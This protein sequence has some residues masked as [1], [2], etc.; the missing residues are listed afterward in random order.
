MLNISNPPHILRP[1]TTKQI[2]LDVIIA[3]IPAFLVSALFFGINAI[4]VIVTSVTA[5]VVFEYLSSRFWFKTKDYTSDLSSVIT[6]LLM[7][8]CLPATIP[9]W[10]II[11]GA[12]IAIVV[13]KMA[14]GGIGKNIFNPALVGRTFLFLSFPIQMTRWPKPNM[15]DF[16]NYD[17]QTGATA[18]EIIKYSDVTTSAT[19]LDNNHF[20]SNIPSFFEMFIGQMSGSIG[21]ISVAAILLGFI[22]LLYKKVITWHVPITYVGTVFFIMFAIAHNS[23]EP[24]K[25]NYY[26]H[27]LSGGLLLGAVFMATDF[28]TSPMTLK[29]KI[30]FAIG[31]GVLTVFIRLNSVYMEGVAFA[32]LIM[33][34]FVPLIDNMTTPKIFGTRKK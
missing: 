10:M 28:V 2:M 12:F 17:T 29:G 32:I 22:Y 27:V 21:E 31:C 30:V 6:G 7:A 11:I 24:F 4:L 34:A 16:W 8:F 1:R 9:L 26:M 19:R 14:F 5:C 15:N 13:T 25:Y 18:L 3:L 20:L 33:N 23:D